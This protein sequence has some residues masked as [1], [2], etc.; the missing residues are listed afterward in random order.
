MS[1][2]YR[3]RRGLQR[4][5]VGLLI[6]AILLVM[7][8]VCWFFWLGRFLVYTR[9]HAL[10]DFSLSQTF[11][12]G[13]DSPSGGSLPSVNIVIQEVNP[14]DGTPVIEQ[15]NI[16]GYYVTLAELKKDLP[17]VREQVE[18]L[19]PGTAILLDMKNIKG[20]FHYSTSVGNTEAS[21]VDVAGIDEFLAYLAESDLY[22][23]ARIPAFR[24]WE[25]GLNHVPDGLPIKGGGGALWI[26]GAGCYWLD[27]TKENVLG[28]L[29]QITTELRSLGF[30]EVVYTEFCF[31]DT[32]RIIYSNDKAQ[33]LADAA[34]ML[35]TACST[36]RFCVSFHTADRAFPL[37][38]GNA[39]LYLE[40]VSAAEIESVAQQA[41][42]DDP[43]IH[44][45]F[46]TDVNDTRF[47]KYSVLRPLNTA[48]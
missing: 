16:M 26:D 46:L 23:I 2:T 29:I 7:V 34:Q 37:P 31:P 43:Y 41:Q 38:E 22:T 21:D 10:F 40:G 35:V 3:T 27:P 1:M 6:A 48:H 11:P 25:Y 4:F 30:D 12:A 19:P 44:L 13:E 14:E 39:R 32:N 20:A 17:S 5:L 8:L 15:T 42:T 18:K 47:N 45:L 9:D 33:A 28:Y 24:D 36:D